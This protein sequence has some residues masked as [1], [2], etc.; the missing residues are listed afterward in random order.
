MAAAE[1]GVE[2]RLADSLDTELAQAE[3]DMEAT[4]ESFE[5]VHRSDQ[6]V[7]KQ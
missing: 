3:T 1:V 4:G 7:R 5:E 2:D 6:N